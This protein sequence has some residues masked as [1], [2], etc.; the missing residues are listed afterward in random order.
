MLVAYIQVLPLDH[1]QGCTLQGFQRS[2]NLARMMLS[3]AV[4][5]GQGAQAPHGVPGVDALGHPP[6]VPD[7]GPVTA[8]HIPVLDVVV[9][10]G[11]VVDQFQ[12][13]RGG[14]RP[15]KVALKGLAGEHAQGRAE[16]LAL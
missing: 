1:L 9:D 7:R 13:S 11:E 10:Q 16:G 4:E 2:E 8:L 3:R 15:G 14:Q 12:G 5:K 6:Q